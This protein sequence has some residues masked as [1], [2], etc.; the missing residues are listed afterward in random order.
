MTHRTP[1]VG[2]FS[3]ESLFSSRE[4]TV[5]AKTLF[6]SCGLVLVVSAWTSGG[7]LQAPPG[8]FKDLNDEIV[9]DA[10]IL[11]GKKQLFIDDYIIEELNGAEKVL[12]QP[13]KHAQNPLIVPDQPWEMNGSYAN[14]TV[15]YDEVDG[16]YKMWCTF[17]LP[18]EENPNAHIGGYAYATSIDGLAW[19]KP[20]INEAGNNRI[21]PPQT[22]GFIGVS[23]YK[24][25]VETD[26]TRRYKLFYNE[27]PDGTPK[28]WSTSVAYSPDGFRWT[29]EPKNPVTPFSD[30]QTHA[31]WDED[32]GRYVGYLRFGPPNTRLISRIESEDFVHWSPKVTVIRRSKIDDPFSTALYGM[33]IMP[34]EGIYIG[35]LTTYHGETIDPIPE[36]EVAW[37]DK[38]DAQL[39]FS[40]NGLTWQRVGRRG[41][42]PQAELSQDKDWKT[43]AEQATFIPHGE[44][45]KEWDWGSIYVYQRPLVVGDEIRFYYSGIGK[46]HWGSYHG[47]PQPSPSGVGLA[48]LRLDGFVSVDAA[49]EGTLTT[50]TLVFI[51]DQIEVNA[52]AASGSIVVEAVDPDGNVI[53]GFS[54]ED[55]AP[56]TTDN[57]RHV[58]E[59][60]DNPDCHLIQARPIK[61]RFYLDNAKLYSFTPRIRHTHYVPSYD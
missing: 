47:D 14:G 25:P 2:A 15:L 30:T 17:W 12:N 22:K 53:E 52:D 34:Y 39:T 26:P 43:I 16:Q 1:S 41:A 10:V 51:G 58:L 20:P 46:R 23:V 9:G 61:L 54:K 4:F 57:V 24:D 49:S 40:R 33:R 5:N 11:N 32:R 56:L 3:P 18:D 48:T 38:S 55:C 45:G 6:L 29:P 19:R 13:V 36:D 50:K 59:W 31:Y 21:V 27:K 7:S 28:T 42:I 35:I 60:R 44:H 37:R 8:L